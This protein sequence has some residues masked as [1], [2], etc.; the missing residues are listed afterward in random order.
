M[1]DRWEQVS[2]IYHALLELPEGERPA[3][4]QSNVHDEEVRREVESLLANEGMA[5]NILE[6]PALEVIAKRI[7]AERPA[8]IL[9]Q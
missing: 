5:R 3:F 4:L 7:A 1:R 9:G 8:S 6:N 2:K